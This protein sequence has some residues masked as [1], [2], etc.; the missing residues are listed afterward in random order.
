MQFLPCSWAS[1]CLALVLLG[2]V[3][4]FALPVQTEDEIEYRFERLWPE[5]PQPAAVEFQ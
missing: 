2:L 1:R 5:L 3:W 4:G